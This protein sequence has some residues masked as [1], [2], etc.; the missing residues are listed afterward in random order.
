VTTSQYLT[1]GDLIVVGDDIW[2][3]ASDDSVVLH[4]STG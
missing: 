4:L 2:T 1:G 3:S